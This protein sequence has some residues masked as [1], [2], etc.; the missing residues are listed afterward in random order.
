MKCSLHG[1]N[2][3]EVSG[4]FCVTARKINAI[5]VMSSNRYLWHTKRTQHY[6]A[7]AAWQINT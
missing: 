5:R 4:C 1:L 7:E 6:K 3:D 2:Q